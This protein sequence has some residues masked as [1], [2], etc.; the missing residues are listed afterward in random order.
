MAGTGIPPHCSTVID[1][2]TTQ[3]R[4][5]DDAEFIL[6]IFMANVARYTQ[7][8]LVAVTVPVSTYRCCYCLICAK[9]ISTKKYH[10]REEE[11]GEEE[12]RRDGVHNVCTFHLPTHATVL[13]HKRRSNLYPTK[14]CTNHR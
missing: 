11:E 10:E 5:K 7:V 8:V 9:K 2:K 13:A 6:R 12:E 14:F 3:T 4:K 1:K